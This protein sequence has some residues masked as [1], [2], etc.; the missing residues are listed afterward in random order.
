MKP[1][2]RTRSFMPRLETLEER[3][4]LSVAPPAELSEGNAAAWTTFTAD[5]KSATVKDDGSRAVVGGRSLR[6]DT[7]SGGDTGIRLKSGAQA[8]DLTAYSQLELWTYSVNPNTAGFQGP[9]PVV[10]LTTTTGTYRFTPRNQAAFQKDGWDKHHIS[11]AGDAFWSRATT[12][13]PNLANVTGLEI[14]QDT[15][16]AAFTVYYDG[17]RFTKTDTA[18]QAPSGPSAPGV[19]AGSAS[20][21]VLLYVFDPL[22]ENKGTQRLHQAYGWA[23]PQQTTRYAIQDLADASDG[24]YRPQVVETRVVDAH[25][26]FTDGFRYTDQ[27]YATAQDTNKYH[28]GTF[29]YARFLRETGLA[30]RIDRGEIDEVWVWAGPGSGLSEAILAGQGAYYLRGP[31]TPAGQRVVPVMGLNSAKGVG[32]ALLAFAHRVEATMNFV[33][34]PLSG[35]ANNA[36]KRFTR[37][38]KDAV[39]QGAVG[40]PDV[41]VNGRWGGDYDNR[42]TVLSTATDWEKYPS[43][44]GTKASLSSTAWSP[45]HAD[46]KRDYLRWW[47]ELLPDAQ[48]LA[49]DGRL[50]NWWRYVADPNSFKTNPDLHG[51]DGSG[52]VWVTGVTP[53]GNVTGALQVGTDG[54][55]DGVWGR[56]DLFVDGVYQSSDTLGPFTFRLD[57]TRLSAGQHT[58][59]VRGYEAQRQTEVRSG[60]VTV[61]V[62]LPNRAPTLD[63]IPTQYIVESGLLTFQAKGKDADV[64]QKLT[65]SLGAGAPAG[66]KIDPTTGAFTWAAPNGPYTATVLVRVTDAG[67]LSATQ[68][69]QLVVSNEPPTARL[70]SSGQ[71]EPGKPVTFSFLDVTDLSVADRAA[72]FKYSFD[73]NNDGDFADPGEVND[74]TQA[75]VAHAFAAAGTYTVH[76]R[77]KDRDG[78]ARD[79]RVTVTIRVPTA[80][81]G[82]GR[83]VDLVPGSGSSSP[84]QLTAVGRTLYFVATTPST[85]EELFRSDGTAAGTRLVADITPGPGGSLPR[86]L[87]NVNGVLFF[88][89]QDADH[90]VELW[91]SDGTAAGTWMVMDINPGVA[92]AWPAKLMGLNGVLYFTAY[93]PASGVELWRS[94]GTEAGTWMVIDL[95]PGTGSGSPDQL[96]Q[97][98]SSLAFVGNRPDVGGELWRTNGTAAGTV[99]IRDVNPG[100]NSSFIAGLLNA[101]GTLFF[102]AYTPQS[103]QELWRS[104]ATNGGTFLVKDIAA[105]SESSSPSGLTALGARVFFTAND[106]HTG[107]EPWVSDGTAAGTRLLADIIPG[108]ES[109][110]PSYLTV[111]NGAIYFAASHSVN[112]VELWRTD[113]TAAGTRLVADVQ[114]GAASS[115]PEALVVSGGQLWFAAWTSA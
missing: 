8:W 38:N 89:A 36:W 104:D 6:F 56:V 68:T 46:P 93:T 103:G 50:N 100:R 9:Q 29:D 79:Y 27:T 20:P 66:A 77:V 112:G 73:W 35:D 76:G 78:G 74:G 43:L 51:S 82:P 19:P 47:L 39:G 64:G 33:Y 67:G 40:T 2:P 41:P 87:T 37:T 69:V 28:A 58:I 59:Q 106:Q 53:N 49:A 13:A 45:T 115:T 22:M 14:H 7:L 24:M 15:T 99:I 17:I 110:A 84:T 32:D 95:T 71:L 91:R 111:Y 114:P 72:G 96:T 85:G 101:S 18:A 62:V 26:Y 90:G 1:T 34:Q 86:N 42:G 12:G 105:G 83:V 57:T 48:G 70:V 54:F 60:V 63:P 97:A 88:T 52:K 81:G 44:T 4:A 23:D 31:A 75:S 102:S 10:V 61:N 11:L 109:S 98:G 16:G 55:V 21:R 65:Y 92:S 80:P 108:A 30:T 3:V 107:G 5:G 113:G 25:P 94:D